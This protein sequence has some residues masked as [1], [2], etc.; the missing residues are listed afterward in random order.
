MAYFDLGLLHKA[1]KRTEKAR[2]CILEAIKIFEKLE[3]ERYLRQAEE[4][5]SSLE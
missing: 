5:L 4:A 1:N 3:L 2:E